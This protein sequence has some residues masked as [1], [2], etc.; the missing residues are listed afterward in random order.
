MDNAITDREKQTVE[1]IMTVW[2]FLIA[3][4]IVIY[5]ALGVAGWVLYCRI[6]KMAGNRPNPKRTWALVLNIIA[7]IFP[8]LCPLFTA[9]IAFGAKAVKDAKNT[10]ILGKQF[11]FSGIEL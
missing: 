6:P 8:G 9:S 10:A 2:I 4:S 3:I 11:G 7:T 1:G 5:I